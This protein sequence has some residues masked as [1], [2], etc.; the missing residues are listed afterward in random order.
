MMVKEYGI[1]LR[2]RKTRMFST[3]ELFWDLSEDT[4][5]FAKSFSENLWAW[6]QDIKLDS[7]KGL[8]HEHDTAQILELYYTLSNIETE[9]TWFEIHSLWVSEFRKPPGASKYSWHLRPSTIRQVYPEFSRDSHIKTL[10]KSGD[11][12]KRLLKWWLF[13]EAFIEDPQS[14]FELF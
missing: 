10:K 6:E 14:V 2:A 12:I 7:D 9:F 3:P 13:Y 11:V 4:L 1:H 8:C 5:V